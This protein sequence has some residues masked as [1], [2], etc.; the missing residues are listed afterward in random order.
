MAALAASIVN[1]APR[2]LECQLL[3]RSSSLITSFAEPGKCAP[4]LD[5]VGVGFVMVVSAGMKL[6]LVV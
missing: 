5:S 6:K 1:F 2:S 4:A 3:F